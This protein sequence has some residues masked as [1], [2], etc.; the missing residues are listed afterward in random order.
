M[1]HYF[2]CD[3]ETKPNRSEAKH[4]YIA[5]WSVPPERESPP[6]AVDGG[7]VELVG[8]ASGRLGRPR[9]RGGREG[10]RGRVGADWEEHVAAAAAA[11]ARGEESFA[12]APLS[13][14]GGGGDRL[15]KHGC[16]SGLGGPSRS[17]VG[18][19]DSA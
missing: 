7:V 8:G 17:P 3:E 15:Q 11:A 12:G 19:C 13:G 5:R 4:T 2:R 9:G 6:G 1:K 10:D 14:E 18:Q 16:R